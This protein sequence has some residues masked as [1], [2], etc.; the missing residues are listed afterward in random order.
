MKVV[1]KDARTRY[2]SND[3]RIRPSTHLQTRR[4]VIKKNKISKISIFRRSAEKRGFSLLN[5]PR[6]LLGDI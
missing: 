1:G 2:L 5:I 3:T 6:R 4:R